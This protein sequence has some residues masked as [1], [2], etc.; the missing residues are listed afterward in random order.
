MVEGVKHLGLDWVEVRKG[1]EGLVAGVLERGD[2]EGVEIEKFGVRR[3]DLR[4]NEVFERYGDGC[5]GT[6]PAVGGDFDDVLRGERV[7]DGDSKD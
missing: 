1:V 5:L 3:M 6:Q 4:E 7:S 2:G